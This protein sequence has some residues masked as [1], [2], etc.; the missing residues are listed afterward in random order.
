MKIGGGGYANPLFVDVA[1]GLIHWYFYDT[2]RENSVSIDLVYNYILCNFFIV[3][4]IT[5][6][7][8]IK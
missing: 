3:N 4:I 7:N 8:M 2:L 1:W 6:Y 5:I